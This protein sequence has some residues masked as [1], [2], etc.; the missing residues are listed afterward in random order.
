MD[1]ALKL[2]WLKTSERRRE[3]FYL[4]LLKKQRWN[5]TELKMLEG[6][7]SLKAKNANKG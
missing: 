2:F 6:D 3:N 1:N 5:E 7:L 4:V